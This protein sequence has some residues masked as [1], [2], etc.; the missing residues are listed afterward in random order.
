M[1]FPLVELLPTPDFTHA[2]L[3]GTVLLPC[4]GSH[5]AG[6]IYLLPPSLPLFSVLLGPEAGKLYFPD[7]PTS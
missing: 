1:T 6:V 3:M 4:R 5:S 2:V 7:S